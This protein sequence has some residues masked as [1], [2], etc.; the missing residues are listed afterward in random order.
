MR[1]S[2]TDKKGRVHTS[3]I[4]VSV[5]KVPENNELNFKESDCEYR[6]I[7]SYGNG[8]QNAQKNSCGV[9]IKH[10]P[11]GLEAKSTSER[12]QLTNKTLALDALKSKLFEIQEKE[13]QSSL[14]SN[15]KKQIGSGHRSDKIRTIRCLDGIVKCEISGRTKSLKAY[16][17]GELE[18]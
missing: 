4:T 11:T 10:L 16:L 5:L 12:S 9:I 1:V 13:R 2:P 18:F 8:G 14:D 3:L 7:K 6:F 15:R 17:K